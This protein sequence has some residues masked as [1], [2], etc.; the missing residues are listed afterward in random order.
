MQQPTVNL[1]IRTSFKTQSNSS[2]FEAGAIAITI[3]KPDGTTTPP[4][5]Y[6]QAQDYTQRI[7]SEIQD[8]ANGSSA[9]LATIV[10][11]T[12][13][14]RK[15][16][17][18]GRRIFSGDDA[19]NLEH[20][21][22]V[23]ITNASGRRYTYLCTSSPEK[24]RST[25]GDVF[26]GIAAAA[27]ANATIE[28]H[29]STHLQFT[30]HSEAP[31]SL[32]KKFF[33][34]REILRSYGSN[35]PVN[36]GNAL[37][38]LNF[39]GADARAAHAKQSMLAQRPP[40][41]PAR[42]LPSARPAAFLG[43]S[44]A[45]AL[46]FPGRDGGLPPRVPERTLA[47]TTD[48][49]ANTSAQGAELDAGDILQYLRS[50]AQAP[51]A[52]PAAGATIRVAQPGPPESAVLKQL[53]KKIDAILIAVIAIQG[54]MLTQPAQGTV[55]S[56]STSQRSASAGPARRRASS[57]KRPSNRTTDAVNNNTALAAAIVAT[58][59]ASVRVPATAPL[60]SSVVAASGANAAGA[61]VA[62]PSASAPAS[63]AA[64][65]GDVGLCAGRDA[66]MGSHLA[67]L[68]TGG[69]SCQLSTQYDR[70]AT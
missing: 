69:G 42:N 18:Q 3:E 30:V 14:R 49:A 6:D 44:Y 9:V 34:Y 38:R 46:R 62:L 28:L 32:S 63:A 64:A 43:A 54:H 48:A 61:S 59:D 33:L 1:N 16:A 47:A 35:D 41:Q 55:A 23:T 45:N 10:R 60:P 37:E 7:Y 68:Q 8:Q 2:L 67:Q 22:V 21:H 40:T 50:N 15:V 58:P 12:D 29:I 52:P 4:A 25:L 31:T 57:T 51:R 24:S 65:V 5:A 36:C 19:V 26:A 13:M 27:A 70:Y 66:S 11:A 56:T 53:E 17:V 39:D 20:Q